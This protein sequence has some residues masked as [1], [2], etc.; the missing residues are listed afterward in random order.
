MSRME[1]ASQVPMTTRG[2]GIFDAGLE[3]HSRQD[4][5]LSLDR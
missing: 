1:K 3:A 2:V 5:S 4:V